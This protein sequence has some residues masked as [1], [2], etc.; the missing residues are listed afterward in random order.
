MAADAHRAAAP[1]TPAAASQLPAPPS[2]CR[3][4]ACTTSRTS[5]WRSRATSSIVVTGLSGSGKSSLAFDTIYA[6]GQRRYMESLSS[7]AKRF[8][9]QVAKPD[10]DFVFG[11]SPVI[12][13]EQKTI[14]QQPA[15][16]RR[17]HDRHRQLPEPALRHHRPAPLP[18]H[19]RAHPQ[20]QR[21]PDPGGH[22]GPARGDRGRAAG[23]GVQGLRRG[24]GLRLHRAAQ[25]GLPPAV[26]RRQARSTSP[27]RWSST[28][29]SVEQ[30]DAVVDRFVVS[31]KHEKAIKAGHRRHPAGGR[32]AHPGPASA[33]AP[34]RPRPS[35][36]T[37]ACAAPR[38]HF[39]YGDIEPAY[40]VFNDPESACRTCGGLGVH[41]LTHPELL[42]PDPSRSIVGGCF[43]REAFRYNPDTC[44]GRI[45]YSL[46]KA[47]KFSLETPWQDLPAK[48]QR[49]HPRTASTAGRS[50]LL[51]PPEA[52]VKRDDWEGKPVGFGGIA[53]RI[54][55]HYRRYRQR[56]E[57]SSGMEEWLDKVMVEHTCPDCQGARLRATR[58]LF[59]VGGKTIYEVGQLHFDELHAFLGIGQAQ[60][61][62]RRRRPAG[63]ARDPRAAAA[64]AGHRAR[65]PEP[66]PPLG[67]AVGRRV[68]ADPAVDADRLG[69]DG[70]AVRARRA[71]HRPAPQGQR[72][73]DR[74]ARAPARHRQHR[75]RGRARRG[76]HPRRRP[77]GG[78]G[79]RPGRARRARWWCRAASTTCW[80]A[81]PRPPGSS[82][83]AGASIAM[84]APPPPGQRQ[85]PSPCAGARENNLKGVDVAFPLGQL[86]A[87][88]GASG[89]GKSTL[90]NEILYKALW[91]RL[92]DTRTLPGDHDGLDGAEHV[93]KVVNIDQSPI[94]R[95]SRS[96][97]ATYVGFY[98]TIRDLFTAAPAVGR[99]RL[100]A[101]TLQL[102]RQGRA[103][104]GVPGRRGDHHPALLHARRGG[105]VRRLQGRALQQ[106]DPRGH[107]ARQDHRRRAE[108]VGRGGG[109]LLRRRAGG[110]QEDRGARTT[111]AWAT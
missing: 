65:L 74:H 52:K 95:N 73:D 86:V 58:Q 46:A 68:A 6:E 72:Q 64:A 18:A 71:E 107:P 41:K 83:R 105:A 61:A 14:A 12:S 8:V 98:D 22:P 21:Q 109:D 44:D 40:F 37:G 100:Q 92:V 11:L 102:Q 9:A 63:A 108:H 17:H 99:A 31:R 2:P 76:H 94:G 97:P 50:P 93:H 16:D 62:R 33:R 13:I 85:A 23:A 5:P 78:D 24:A 25:E 42:V 39:V 106:R 111:W 36:S 43:V 56:G 47:L 34:A 103:L 15:L 38:H 90:V 10:V 69:P 104:R 26:H 1:P 27:T 30:M 84:P 4:R 59:T 54:E 75:D 35:A 49:R 32:R 7:F 110:G 79:P 57:A 55:R 48:A 101:G 60:R 82:S 77:P 20:P 66:Q 3:A 96:N 89:S 81:R 70:H 67:H 45:M 29:A 88:T 53:R 80:P 91:K 28:A 19:G 51:S 87:I